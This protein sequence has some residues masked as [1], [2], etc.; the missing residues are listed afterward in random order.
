M[1][2]LK[3]LTGLLAM[4][5]VFCLAG[6]SAPDDNNSKEKTVFSYVMD[7]L[8]PF[9]NTDE[10][11]VTLNRW[12][13]V[14]ANLG[15]K[16]YDKW[17]RETG[18][19]LF[20]DKALTQ[21]FL[22][23]DLVQANT[24]IYSDFSL[25]GQGPKIGTI[26]GT[27]K[28]TGIPSEKVKLYVI[29]DS[30]NWM[31]LGKVTLINPIEENRDMNWSFP[32]YDMYVND[33]G[34]KRG[35]EPSESGFTLIVLPETAKKGYEVTVPTK[36]MINNANEDIGSL[37]TVSVQGVK[38]SG[39][40]NVTHNGQPVPYVEIQAVWEVK[41]ILE[42]IYLLSPGP[43]EPWSI[44]IEKSNAERD[45]TFRVLGV[46]KPDYTY[47]DIII[48]SYANKDDTRYTLYVTSNDVSDITIDLSNEQ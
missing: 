48:D 42:T 22:G 46:T 40:V 15:G 26:T 18:N 2:V 4:A 7:E 9:F 6:C 32:V 20:K 30:K 44:Y 19:I 5:L 16:D 36:K 24:V 33:R 31:S 21:K 35:F 13:L 47:K 11:T 23:S 41:G 12:F 45:I 8:A 34:G 17:T 37:D 39:T 28:L 27:I 10:K 25:N 43:N 14:N 38:L 1:T 29:A 3:K